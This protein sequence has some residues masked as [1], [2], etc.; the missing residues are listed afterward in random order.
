[1][2]IGLIY[3]SDTGN[4]ETV[5][6]TLRAKIGEE[7]VDIHNI[8]KADLISI[9]QQNYDFFIL[10]IP[11]WY[12]GQ[13]QSDWEDQIAELKKTNFSGRKVAIYGLGDQEDWGDYFCDGVGTLADEIRELGAVLIGA[14]PSE[15]YD[16]VESLALIDDDTFVGLVLDEDRQPELTEDRINTWIAQL[17]RELGVMHW[18][19]HLANDEALVQA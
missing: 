11:T 16:F 10:G 15:G 19:E 2:K 9:I 3:G 6:E 17:K 13:M 18:H 14:W 7:V 1:M 12:D 8:F 5:A 4:T